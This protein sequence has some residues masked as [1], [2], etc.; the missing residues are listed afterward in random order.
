MDTEYLYFSYSKYFEEKRKK[1]EKKIIRDGSG[2]L[3]LFLMYCSK[4]IYQKIFS[5][6]TMD[7]RDDLQTT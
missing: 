6:M 2:R 3:G 5:M 7:V 1:N 4:L